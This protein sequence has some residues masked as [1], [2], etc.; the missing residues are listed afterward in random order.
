MSALSALRAPLP[1]QSRRAPRRA[2]LAARAT[3]EEPLTSDDAWTLPATRLSGDQ[4]AELKSRLLQLCAV[5][6]RGQA[7]D[8]TQKIDVEDAILRLEDCAADA[9]LQQ[10]GTWRL[11]YSSVEPF[12]S[13]PFFAAFQS[14]VGSEDV[15]SAVFRLTA[16]LPVAGSSGALGAVTQRVS[17][18]SGQGRLVSEVSLSLYGAVSGTVVTEARLRREETDPR[19]TLR[20]VV[21]ST[22][23]TGS[24]LPFALDSL[25]APVEAAFAALKGAPLEVMLHCRFADASLRVVRTGERQDQLFVY[26]REG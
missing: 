19:G 5:T 4:V 2:R 3:L 20:C 9:A 10:E 18:A 26:A 25:A 21:E 7:A 6:A 24:S 13:S 8:F 17:L 11:V 1:V 23:V 22:R 15:A 16:S 14:F 12:R